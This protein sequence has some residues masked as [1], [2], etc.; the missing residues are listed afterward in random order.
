MGALLRRAPCF[1]GTLLIGAGSTGQEGRSHVVVARDGGAGADGLD[2]LL[3]H[4]G[5]GDAALISHP[6]PLARDS[7]LDQLRASDQ[8]SSSHALRQY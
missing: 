3:V 4:A 2:L 5:P 6:H 1:S 7:R 8:L